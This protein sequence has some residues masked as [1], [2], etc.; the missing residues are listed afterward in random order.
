M[1]FELRALSGEKDLVVPAVEVRGE[2][3]ASN[4]ADFSSALS[5]YASPAL[6]IDLSPAMYF[7]SAGFA[8]IDQLLHDASV[9]VVIAPG[10]A[11]RTAAEIV[12]LPFYD[13]IDEAVAGIRAR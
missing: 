12:S 5:A 4:V 13:T 7:D 1:S 2:V 6:I 10:S 9:A 8:M 3:D 11:L